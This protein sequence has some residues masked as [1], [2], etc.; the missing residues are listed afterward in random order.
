MF[1]ELLS[2]FQKAF[3]RLRTAVMNPFR[4]V[5]RRTQQLSNANLITAKLINPIN[6]KLREIFSFKPKAKED[7]ITVGNFWISRKVIYFLIIAICAGVFIY[8]TW[9]AS[10][11][12]ETTTTTNVVTTTYFDY[13]DLKLAEFSGKANIRAANGSVVYTGD[14]AAGMITGVGTLW[15]QDGLLIYEGNFLNNQYSGVGTLYY[16]NGNVMSH[17]EFAEHLFQGTGYS[18]SLEGNLLYE[19][20]FEKGSF[21]GEG[22]S[23]NEE[24]NLIYEGNFQSGNYH[25]NGILYYANGIKKYEGEFYQ[26]KAQG[27]GTSYSN[28]GKL[29]FTGLFARNE[30]HYESLLGIT[31]EDAMSMF[32]E[33]PVVY[34]SEVDTVFLF[35]GA[36]VALKGD[37]MVQLL[38]DSSALSTDDDWY[39]PGEE[40][41]TLTDDTIPT[42]TIVFD[43]NG[44]GSLLGEGTSVGED[45]NTTTTSV[46]TTTDADGN[47]VTTTTTTDTTASTVNTTTMLDG[48]EL[49]VLATGDTFSAYYYLSSDEWQKA[50]ELDKTQITISSVTAYSDDLDVAFLE[51]TDMTAANG[52]TNL[53]DCVAIDRIRR[54]DPTAFSNNSFEMT[55]KNKSYI[56]VSGINM[57]E[58]VYSE[59]YELEGVRYKL[60]YQMDNPEALKF[61]TLEVY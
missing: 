5:I 56:Y 11:V 17:G 23:Y 57:A 18:Y 28:T 4:R 45:E 40:E 20:S 47:E 54:D 1:S 22:I 55:T 60:C 14:V 19:G 21:N 30:I 53:I 37:C 7:Y 36:H 58:A 3:V 44:E 59:I 43:E 8:F 16:P 25:G 38:R 48:I 32:G 27:Q 31:L 41:D 9:F 35:E 24:G 6:K 49:P 15:N 39:L 2:L 51:N 29:L 33:T 52:V 42:D 34:Y 26:G 10:D 61:I 46:T 12:Q 50:E 13:D